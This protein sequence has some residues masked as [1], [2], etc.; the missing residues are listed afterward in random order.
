VEQV[1]QIICDRMQH[2]SM[3][4]GMHARELFAA[5][6]YG[7]VDWG[8]WGQVIHLDSDPKHTG[9]CARVYRGKHGDSKLAVQ[10]RS[11]AALPSCL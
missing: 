3:P 7:N 10:A 6:A 8:E 4:G 2:A 5:H 11:A 1:L 9:T